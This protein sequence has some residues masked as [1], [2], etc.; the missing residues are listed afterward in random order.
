MILTRAVALLVGA[1]YVVTGL[2]SFLTPEGFFGSVANFAPYNVHLLHD[3]GAF[4]VGLGLALVLPAALGRALVTSLAAV[5][6]ASLLAHF[7]DLSLGGHPGFG[8]AHPRPR[9]PPA[10]GRHRG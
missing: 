9:V 6:G 4:Q 7:E 5:L 3:L 1:F 2:W 10:P 8:P